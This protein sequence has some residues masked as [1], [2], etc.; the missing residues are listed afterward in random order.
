MYAIVVG[1]INCIPFVR[2]T[3]D[4][5]QNPLDA[6]LKMWNSTVLVKCSCKVHIGF[7]ISRKISST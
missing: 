5:W 2:V 1:T 7:V 4:L 6:L 3:V